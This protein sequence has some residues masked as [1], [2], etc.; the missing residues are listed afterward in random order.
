MCQLGDYRENKTDMP[1]TFME[2]T[3]VWGNPGME[4]IQSAGC[5]HSTK[6]GF[7]RMAPE[8]W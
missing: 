5:V 3:S 1:P 2:L 8:P 7:F 6:M 4:A